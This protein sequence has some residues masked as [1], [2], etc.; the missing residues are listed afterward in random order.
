MK[1]NDITGRYRRGQVGVGIEMGRPGIGTSVRDLEIVA[2][3]LARLGVEFEPLNPVAALMADVKTGKFK[4]EVLRE[5][6]LSA[7]IEIEVERDELR[8]ILRTI[9]E[10]AK[11]VDSVFTLDAFTILEPG[12][13]IPEEV[14]EEIRAEGFTWR[15]NAKINMGLGRAWE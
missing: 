3:A 1:T 14:L 2:M 10:V 15:P 12:L 13:T 6:V 7:I 8:G 4:E 5:R 11:E 9:K